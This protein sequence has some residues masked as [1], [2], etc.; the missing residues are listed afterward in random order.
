MR[1]SGRGLA[2]EGLEGG[3]RVALIKEGDEGVGWFE[4][5]W[6]RGKV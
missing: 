1:G 2:N 5:R 4:T 3:P 6:D